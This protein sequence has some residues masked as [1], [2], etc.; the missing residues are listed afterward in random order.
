MFE[1]P[2]HWKL[3]IAVLPEGPDLSLVQFQNSVNN[4]NEDIYGILIKLRVEVML[5]RRAI[6][7]D[8][9]I[10]IKQDIPDP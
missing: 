10:R 8:D 3:A 6:L 4:S 7:L 5:R 9:I 1:G 2:K